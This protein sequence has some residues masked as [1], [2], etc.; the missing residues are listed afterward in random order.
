MGAWGVGSFQNDQALE[1]LGEVE[2]EDDPALIEDALGTISEADEDAYLD[3]DDCNVAIAAA[4]LVAAMG[5]Q[6]SPRL[7]D[8]MKEW[9]DE[10]EDPEPELVAD[11]VTAIERI[12]KDS[13]LVEQY[14]EDGELDPRWKKS[15]DDLV[16]RLKAASTSEA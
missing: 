15:L 14:T 16:K 12:G 9:C 2:S 6:P 11:A 8:G 5:G 1:W 13:E 7:P 4:E 3:A 10:Q